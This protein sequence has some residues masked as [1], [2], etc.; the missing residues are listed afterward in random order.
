MP[1]SQYPQD[2]NPAQSDTEEET[3]HKILKILD[4]ARTGDYPLQVENV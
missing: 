4:D 2:T 3:L 1:E